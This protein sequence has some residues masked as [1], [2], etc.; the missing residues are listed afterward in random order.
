MGLCG[1]SG[2]IRSA[3]IRFSPAVFRRLGA[4]KQNQS[5][6]S[7]IA[8]G[9]LRSN[10]NTLWPEPSPTGGALV[11]EWGAQ[12]ASAYWFIDQAGRRAFPRDLRN[13]RFVYAR[14]RP[15]SNN[16]RAVRDRFLYRYIGIS[17]SPTPTLTPRTSR[18]AKNTFSNDWTH[19]ARFASTFQVLDHR[20]R[21]PQRNRLEN[22]LS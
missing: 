22:G 4:V 1:K 12:S 17:C 3:G 18:S 19:I 15:V 7:S 6:A 8:P 20:C 11:R 2:K 10:H 14:S 16:L 21:Q 13:H 5:S 9:L